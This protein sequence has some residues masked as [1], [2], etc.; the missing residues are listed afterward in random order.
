MVLN[1]LIKNENPNICGTGGQRVKY[2]TVNIK[3]DFL[4]EVFSSR[5]K[6]EIASAIPAS[7]E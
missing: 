7:N 1:V 5:L 6:L 3:T 2:T 4:V